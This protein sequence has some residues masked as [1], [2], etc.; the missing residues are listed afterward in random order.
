MIYRYKYVDECLSTLRHG[1]GFACQQKVLKTFPGPGCLRSVKG[2]TMVF[3]GKFAYLYIV[4]Q[5]T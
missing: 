4:S 5:K 3:L 1:C 2:M